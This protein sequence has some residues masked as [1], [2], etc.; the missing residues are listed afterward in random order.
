VRARAGTMGQIA[1]ILHQRGDTDEALR[2]RR[3]EEVP[4]FEPL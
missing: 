1:D 2:I 4:V 3:E